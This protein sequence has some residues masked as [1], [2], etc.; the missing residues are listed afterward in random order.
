MMELILRTGFQSSRRIFK[1]TLPSRSILGWYT[2]TK[3]SPINRISLFKRCKEKLNRYRVYRWCIFLFTDNWEN[4]MIPSTEWTT[5]HTMQTKRSFSS[6]ISLPWSCISPSVLHAGTPVRLRN[7]RQMYHLC[8][9]IRVESDKIRQLRKYL[10]D[11][12]LIP[13]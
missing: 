7:W 10:S 6:K 4:V 3:N 9:N 11:M 2:W 8:K 5:Q 12:Y 1:Q 13:D